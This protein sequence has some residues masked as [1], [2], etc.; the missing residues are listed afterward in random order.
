MTLTNGLA[1]EEAEI[2]VTVLP[3]ESTVSSRFLE[4]LSGLAQQEEEKEDVR[5]PETFEGRRLSYRSLD[6][7]GNEILLFMGPLAAAVLGPK[8]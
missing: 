6:S 8:R 7:S 2:P 5:L 3:L 1:A 4:F